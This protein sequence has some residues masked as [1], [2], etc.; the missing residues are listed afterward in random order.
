[1]PAALN[2][3]ECSLAD[4]RMM[5]RAA[6][7]RARKKPLI[8]EPLAFTD[9]TAYRPSAQG[10]KISL[11]PICRK[12]GHDY[13]VRGV[14]MM[15]PPTLSSPKAAPLITLPTLPPQRLL[16]L[17]TVDKF[18]FNLL[19]PSSLAAA[20]AESRGIWTTPRGVSRIR[21]GGKLLP[22]EVGEEMHLGVEGGGRER[23][24]KL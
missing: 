9:R 2:G 21:T 4:S 23:T 5:V 8:N 10:S 16:R 15:G 22:G 7:E 17:F 14:Q 12:L 3:Q 1:M 6:L 19:L 11:M 24:K 20:E 18:F 13:E